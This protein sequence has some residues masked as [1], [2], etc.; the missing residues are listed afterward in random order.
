VKQNSL[1]KINA[2]LI[3]ALFGTGAHAAGADKEL[4]DILLKN[5]SINQSQY[6]SMLGKEGLA[7]SQ[8]LEILSKN[9][10]ITKDQY[11][12]LTKK[13]P[14][15]VAAA[16]APVSPPPSADRPKSNFDGTH[17]TFG[18]NG[19]LELVSNVKE[20]KKDKDGK[21]VLDKDGKTTLAKDPDGTILEA[22]GPDGKPIKEFS[23]KIGGRMQLDSQVAF[24]G[25]NDNSL[26]DAPHYNTALADGAGF[27]RLRLYFEGT[28]FKDYD[29]RF[30]YDF[31]RGNG[32]VAAGI[33]DAFVRYMHFKPF[34]ITLGQQNEGKSLE[35]VMSNNYMPFIERSLPNN[36]FIEFNN[37]YQ[38]GI[39]AES[40]GT[41]LKSD[42]YDGLGWN[43]KGGLTTEGV[44]G[45][46]NSS[47]NSNGNTNR[48]GFSNNESWQLV[49]RGALM[50]YKDKNGNLLHTGVWGSYRD[51]QNN[52]NPDG[53]FRNGGWSFAS[54]PDT[55]IDRTN[56]VN[57]GGLT[58]G[59]YGAV[60]SKRA[61]NISM[62]G[63]EVAGVF[64]PAW[65]AAEYMQTTVSGFGYQNDTMR[66]YYVQGGYFITG[67]SKSWDEKRAAWHRLSPKRNFDLNG[68]WGALEA[69]ARFDLIDMNTTNIHG[70]SMDIGTL[71]LNWYLNPNLR[72]MTNFVHVFNVASITTASGAK[73]SCNSA[74][75]LI[76]G[77]PN[78]A[79]FSGLSP[80]VWEMALRVDY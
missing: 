1:K 5:G 77:N 78:S 8:L 36:A 55:P 59:K 46:G 79:C 7:S 19:V 58:F 49:G 9:G 72:L 21:P 51:L 13:D 54:Q 74:A 15:L 70:G 33:T 31:A 68:G 32:T 37:K 42:S 20:I 14:A 45:G 75:V 62:F 69:A 56:W 6:N 57:T 28:M 44:G 71:G 26:A 25:S 12:S 47:V 63:A 22:K 18:Q 80:N 41:T 24:N 17:I 30:E 61:D 48:N 40:F 23:F 66:G 53:S 67:E 73:V 3:L 29:Y 4:L 38:V 39:M 50:P 65:L 52:Y 27:R 60:G 35:S 11:S 43:L 16:P 2:L 64:G 76:G 34:V 10:T